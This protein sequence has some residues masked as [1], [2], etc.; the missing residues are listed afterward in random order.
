MAKK[1]VVTTLG[2]VPSI[3]ISPDYPDAARIIK[4]MIGLARIRGNGKEVLALSESRKKFLIWIED[5]RAEEA[6]AARDAQAELDRNAA[7]EK[8]VPNGCS[9]NPDPKPV[10]PFDNPDHPSNK[11]GA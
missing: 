10:T 4:H 2:S 7:A 6:Q 11:S 1:A 8:A 3:I 5:R 9:S